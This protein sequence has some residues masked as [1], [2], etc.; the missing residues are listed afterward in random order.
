ML[1]FPTVWLV[2]CWLLLVT[3]HWD[4]NRVYSSATRCSRHYAGASVILWTQLYS[5]GI[6]RVIF[7]CHSVYVIP[8]E[9][10]IRAHWTS[11][12][13]LGDGRGTAERVICA[14]KDCCGFLSSWRLKQEWWYC[15]SPFLPV[16]AEVR[17]CTCM[18]V[19]NDCKLFFFFLLNCCIGHIKYTISPVSLALTSL[20]HAI[21]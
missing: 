5:V 6:R 13:P 12:P 9:T 14:I 17:W 7:W 3:W 10:T 20:V 11:T 4:R 15:C 19:T 2:G 18:I 16:C 1:N 21:I 8:G